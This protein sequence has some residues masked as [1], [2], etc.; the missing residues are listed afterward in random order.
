MSKNSAI[1][2]LV[3]SY[4]MVSGGIY[5]ALKTNSRELETRAIATILDDSAFFFLEGELVAGM[6]TQT[7][8]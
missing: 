5:L 4:R 8:R 2:P 6:E 3:V 7:S 1:Q